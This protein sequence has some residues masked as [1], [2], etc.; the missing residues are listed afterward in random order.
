MLSQGKTHRKLLLMLSVEP[1]LV[2]PTHNGRAPISCHS[3]Q[4]G[5]VFASLK[6]NYTPSLLLPNDNAFA[7]PG[8][9]M[10]AARH[11][12]PLCKSEINEARK[13]AH[14][15]ISFKPR[16]SNSPAQLSSR[17]NSLDPDQR[18]GN[19]ALPRHNAVANWPASR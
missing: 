5:V 16:S 1:V 17:A 19:S 7:P 11:S 3:L 4:P 12:R 10:E 14:E 18:R 6:L 8:G 2:P 9:I 13:V 15:S